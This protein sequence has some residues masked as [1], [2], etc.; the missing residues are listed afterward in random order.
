MYKLI[1][2]AGGCF[3]GTEAYFSKLKGVARTQCG[4]ANGNT[5]NPTYEE[6]CRADTGHAETVLVEYDSTVISTEKILTEFFKTIDP[7]TKNRQGN[8]FG[9]QYRSGVYYIDETDAPEIQSYVQ[10]KQEEYARPIVTEILPLLRYFPA[11][12]HHQRYLD[13]NPNGYCHVNLNLIQDEDRCCK[14]L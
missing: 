10:K 11:E 8:D 12:E 14:R 13:K 1:Y 7:T 9:S 2:L 3:W 5:V 6:V 4:Y